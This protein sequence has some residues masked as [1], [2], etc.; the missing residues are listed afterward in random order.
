MNKKVLLIGGNFS[1]ELTGIGKYNGEMIEILA[2]QGYECTVVTSFPYYPHWTVQPPYT[3]SGNWFKREMKLP[4]QKGSKSIEIFRCPHFIPQKPSGLKRIVA[5]FSFCFA[6]FIKICHLLFFRK[7]NFVLVVAPPFQLG[8]LGILVQ[9]IKGAKF[10]YHVQDLQIDAARDL[11]LIKSKRLIKFLFKV[12]KYILKRADVV[13][14][15][16]EGMIKKIVLK[17]PREVVFFPNWVDTALFFPIPDRDHL[18]LE[19]GFEKT[20][21]IVLYSGAIG[22]KQGLEAILQA[23]KSLESIKHLKWVICGSGPYKEKLI[24]KQKSQC[25]EN[26]F[27]LPLQPFEKLNDFLNMADLH[28]VL[29]KA[30]AADLVMPSKLTAILSVG[31]SAIITANEGSSLYD[32]VAMHKMGVLINP[33]DPVALTDA[34][35]QAI[36]SSDNSIELNARGYARKYLSIEAIFKNYT[37]HLQ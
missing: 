32:V 13:S 33:E 31:G 10:L 6:A 16:S 21:K 28:L 22:E 1:P 30:N 23:A 8:L 3:R 14:S 29:Q 34:I 7:F 27:F 17:Y 37:R 18:K 12:E 35:E 26:V 4:E 25:L 9:K 15:I 5:D 11:N 2:K 36:K 24:Q 20:D 19:F